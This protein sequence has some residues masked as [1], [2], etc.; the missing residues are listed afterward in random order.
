MIHFF[1]TTY[2]KAIVRF[3]IL[4]KIKRYIKNKLLKRFLVQLL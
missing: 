4:Y 1:I 2:K 3:F